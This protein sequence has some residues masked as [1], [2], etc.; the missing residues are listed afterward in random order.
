MITLDAGACT[1]CNLCVRVCPAHAIEPGPAVSERRCI[2]CGHC[3]AV[4]PSG[5]IALEEFTAADLTPV[6]SG[7]GAGDLLGLLASRRSGRAYRREPISREHL[8]GLVRAASLAPSAH[9]GRPVRAYVYT[10]PVAL[11]RVRVKVLAFYRKYAK[12]FRTPGL[13][14]VGCTMGYKPRELRALA[15]ALAELSDPAAKDDRLFYGAPAVLVFGSRRSD[16]MTVADGWLAAANAGLSRRGS[17]ADKRTPDRSRSRRS[18]S[19]SA[20]VDA[21]GFS[22]RTWQ[23]RRTASRLARPLWA[24]GQNTVTTSGLALSSISR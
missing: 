10:D 11:E 22:L 5:A 1:R 4:C 23:P 13:N 20:T 2:E 7:I 14:L 17:T 9:N 15:S 12:L 21:I 16:A 18:I 3:F 24:Y 8:E 6:G 19:S